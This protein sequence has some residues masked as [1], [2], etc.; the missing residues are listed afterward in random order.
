MYLNPVSTFPDQTLYEARLGSCQGS[1]AI[2]ELSRE[3]LRWLSS[4]C[5]VHSPILQI[6]SDVVQAVTKHELSYLLWK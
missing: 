4:G 3:Y 5:L 2:V 6:M 1:R